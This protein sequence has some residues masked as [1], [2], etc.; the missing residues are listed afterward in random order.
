MKQ[1]KF[2]AENIDQ[3]LA[4]K[5]IKIGKRCGLSTMPGIG[6]YFNELTRRFY[7]T[8]QDA[9]RKYGGHQRAACYGKCNEEV[10]VFLEKNSREALKKANELL[11]SL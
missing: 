6:I 2:T 7:V 8:T 10:F 9:A 1:V 11:R 3:A 5:I 4:G